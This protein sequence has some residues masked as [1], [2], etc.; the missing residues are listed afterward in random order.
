LFHVVDDNSFIREFL[1]ELLKDLG[2]ETM[3][4]ECPQKYINFVNSDDYKRPTAIFT[5]VTM[6]I[7]NGYEMI[8]IVAE[9]IA[10]IKFVVMTGEPHI[11]SEYIAKSCM[12]IGK[13]F[14]PQIITGVVARA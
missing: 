7:M 9:L 5:D 3:D 2:F 1:G 8:N 13:P 10:G 14:A 11:R 12:Y 4:F 6:P